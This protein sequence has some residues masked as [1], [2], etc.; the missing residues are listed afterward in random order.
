MFRLLHVQILFR[1]DMSGI[2]L[3]LGQSIAKLKVSSPTYT[4]PY[5]HAKLK[6][7]FGPTAAHKHLEHVSR[8]VKTMVTDEKL[9]KV[10]TPPTPPSPP[11]APPSPPP[12]PLPPPPL[13]AAAAFSAA[14][15]QSIMILSSGFDLEEPLL[16]SGFDLEEPLDLRAGKSAGIALDYEKGCLVS[17]LYDRSE[18]PSEAVL[19]GHINELLDAY[20]KVLKDEFYASNIKRPIDAELEAVDRRLHTGYE[21]DDKARARS[22]G[23]E[24]RVGSGKT[25]KGGN[26][27]GEKAPSGRKRPAVGSK[28]PAARGGA[29]GAAPRRASPGT[30]AARAGGT[31]PAASARPAGSGAGASRIAKSGGAKRPVGSAEEDA[32]RKAPFA[33][34]P[35]AAGEDGSGSEL[36]GEA[37]GGEMLGPPAKR[38]KA[39]AAAVMAAEA[40]TAGGGDSDDDVPLSVRIAFWGLTACPLLPS[41]CPP[42][43]QIAL[44]GQRKLGAS[45]A[46]PAPSLG[47][48]TKGVKPPLAP[49]ARVPGFGQG[50]PA[51]PLSVGRGKPA[52]ALSSVPAARG[53]GKP[54]HPLAS[55]GVKIAGSFGQGKPAHALSTA[56]VGKKP[57]AA[58]LGGGGQEGD[59]PI[60]IT[61]FE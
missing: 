48:K 43:L 58:L 23:R 57:A 45:P 14:K 36:G 40:A 53:V 35:K 29:G 18:I 6:A 55:G 13:P 42:R 59:Y 2:Y 16:S 46:P 4:P 26:L 32:S 47:P 9:L 3:T 56:A 38:A 15:R 7:A 52:H 10:T 33:K 5:P 8:F 11:P 54:P 28:G 22:D 17:R 27:P 61:V 20:A 12:T 21:P 1:A 49:V 41:P 19:L 34:R 60:I 30:G 24:S 39:A 51:H 44:Q 37:G 25:T 31:A 50:K